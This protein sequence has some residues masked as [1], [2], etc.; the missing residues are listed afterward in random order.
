MSL[1]AALKAYARSIGLDVVR[2][3]R[4]RPWP[5]VEAVVVSRVRAGLMDGLP[6]FTEERVRFSCNPE[7]LLPGVRSIIAVALNYYTPTSPPPD[8]QPRGQIARYAW[9]SDYHTV[10]KERLALLRDFLLARVP[11]ARCVISVDTGR[12][13]DRVVAVQAGLGWYGK[14]TC[15]LVPG[16]G[17]WVF[18]GELLTT[19]DLDPDPPLRKHCGRCTACLHVCP[20]G[21]LLG[22]GIIDNRRCIA[23]LTIELRGSIP[24]DLR[25][26]IG[27]WVFG[28]D[29]CQLVCPVNRQARPTG[30][31]RLQPAPDFDP[32]PPLLPLLRLTPE[33]FRQRFRHSA[34]GRARRQGLLRNVCVALGNLG[35]P[36]AVP[37]L[38]TVLATEPDPV[39]REHAAWALGRIGGP[40][41]RRALETA[42]GR[43]TDPTVQREIALSLADL[44]ARQDRPAVCPVRPGMAGVGD[45]RAGEMVAEVLGV[46]SGPVVG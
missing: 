23:F 14:N 21:A 30:D 28:C 34:I 11:G 16:Y 26:L 31:P 13:V 29:L 15:V 38:A 24:R 12:I 2:I 3:A 20:T 22:P 7:N 1:T 8:D 6:W 44:A 18:L 5:E 35:D 9:G 45:S 46:A 27:T 17:S 10:L 32:F 19:V 25:P 43:E 37:A 41:A 42:A 39:V 33:E 40:A 36:R 4:A